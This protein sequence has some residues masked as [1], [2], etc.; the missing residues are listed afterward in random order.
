MAESDA[1]LTAWQAFWKGFLHPFD[2]GPTG[3]VNPI[4]GERMVATEIPIISDAGKAIKSLASDVKGVLSGVSGTFKNL[5][6]Y[7]F[8]IIGI[9]G[10]YLIIMGTKGKRVW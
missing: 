2:L 5:P 6:K 10:V 1:P 4:T 7:I 9:L 8:I 3:D